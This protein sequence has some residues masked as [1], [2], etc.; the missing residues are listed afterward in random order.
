MGPD[1]Y[2]AEIGLIPLPADELAAVRAAV[3]AMGGAGN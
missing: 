2:L 1:G 3:D